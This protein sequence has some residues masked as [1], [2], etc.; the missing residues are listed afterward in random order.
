MPDWYAEECINDGRLDDVVGL[1]EK[2]GNACVNHFYL[3]GKKSR[4]GL[5]HYNLPP[6]YQIPHWPEQ[7]SVREPENELTDLDD[8]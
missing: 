2:I 7:S 8:L 1:Y 5:F 4:A 3:F 6:K